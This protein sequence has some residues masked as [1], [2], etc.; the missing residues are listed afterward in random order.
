MGEH[1]KNFFF[2]LFLVDF[3]IATQ[4]ALVSLFSQN[5]AILD[6]HWISQ[7]FLLSLFLA[8]LVFLF[9]SGLSQ[10]PS[11]AKNII[12]IGLVFIALGSFIDLF[13]NNQNLFLF[14]RILGGLGA[15]ITLAGQMSIIWY[16]QLKKSLLFSSALIASIF[17]GLLTGPKLIQLLAGPALSA[18][19]IS[20][21]LGMFFPI[22]A[23]FEK[24][25]AS[26]ETVLKN[27][28]AFLGVHWKKLTGM[29]AYQ[30]AQWFLDNPVWIFAELTWQANGVKLMILLALI[31]NFGLLF[32]YRGKKVS[33][34]SLDVA[35]DFLHERKETLT[36]LFFQLVSPKMLIVFV[37]VALLSPD[38]LLILQ[39]LFLLL[40]AFGLIILALRGVGTKWESFVAFFALS[41]WQDSFIT[42]AY[43]RRKDSVTG[44]SA[45]DYIIF[46]LSFAVSISYWAIRNG[47]IAEL[48]IRP[49]L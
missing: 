45:K 2:Y 29:G 34:L 6:A 42:T 13:P 36:K 35:V 20:F 32:Y 11:L 39:G 21:L 28:S 4:I 48:I 9:F 23:I 14:G 49:I 38:Y 22:L 47:L 7:G 18:P 24:I 5:L 41:V 19:N 25:T 3:V 16:S 1:K 26:L 40:L 46:F 30:I 17:L 15:G 43:L 44:L 10:D 31:H 12:R 33:W 27:F 37:T 8:F